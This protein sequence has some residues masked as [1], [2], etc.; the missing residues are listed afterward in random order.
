MSDTSL[1][2]SYIWHKGKCFYV[3]TFDRD[4]SAMLGPRRYAETIV[5]EF[6][7]DK[8]ER[9]SILDQG[10]GTAGTIFTHLQMCQFLLDT[11]KPVGDIEDGN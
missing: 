3:S 4:S 9:G 2:K 7:W 8:N 11:G 1:I 6:D 5:W 10:H